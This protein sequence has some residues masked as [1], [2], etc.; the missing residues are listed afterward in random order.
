MDSTMK[1]IIKT[2]TSMIKKQYAKK[3]T[4]K[5]HT[6]CRGFNLIF[7]FNFKFFL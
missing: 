2:T 1:T 5:K 7:A 4:T 6:R 3:K